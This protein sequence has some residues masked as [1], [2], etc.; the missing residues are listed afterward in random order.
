MGAM[1]TQYKFTLK[2]CHPTLISKGVG[3]GILPSLGD[4]AQLEGVSP[5]GR[6]KGGHRVGGWEEKAV[7]IGGLPQMLNYHRR[8]GRI[9]VTYL[10]Q[11]DPRMC[12]QDRRIAWPYQGMDQAT[13]C[14]LYETMCKWSVNAP[15][16]GLRND[17]QWNVCR[18]SVN[19]P[20][21][22]CVGA[23]VVDVQERFP[24][25]TEGIRLKCL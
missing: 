10:L 16:G 11:E 19:A 18:W 2:Y 13:D 20:K 9:L 1:S 7:Q 21:G 12:L 15:C 17:V 25:W 4:Q 5:P 23:P 8:A 3:A 24:E 14:W 6:I 22:I